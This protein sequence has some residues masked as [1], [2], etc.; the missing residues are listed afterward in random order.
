MTS[1]RARLFVSLALFIIATGLSAGALAF[2]WAFDEA[3]ELQDAILLQIGSLAAVNRLQTELPAQDGVDAEAK[4][5]IEDLRKAPD[6]GQSATT[7]PEIPPNFADGLYTLAG[8]DEAWRVLLR[9]RADGG[10]VAVAQPTAARDEIAR[11]SALRTVLP[12]GALIPCLMFLIAV[13]IHF[14]FRP[15]AQLAAKLD[16]EK[17][18]HLQPLP[19]DRMPDELRPFIGSINRLLERVAATF[20]QQRRF[21]ALAA[22]ELRTPLTALSVQADNLDHAMLAQDRQDRLA[23]LRAGIRRTAHLLEQI[24]D[25]AKYDEGA[26]PDVPA[27]RL[28]RVVKSVVADF[29]PLAGARS[30]DLGFAR[31]AETSVQIGATSLS[32]LIRNLLDNAIRHSPDGGRVDV[33]VFPEGPCA[34]L[35][36]ED[37][38]PGIPTTDI[39]RVFEPFDR[40]SRPD[41]DGTGLGLS[42]VRRIVNNGQGSII[43]ENASS[44]G[45]AGLRATVKLPLA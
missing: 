17:N 18:D 5:V 42:I 34:V 28:D 41:G 24:L 40:G 36:I 43:L 13:V 8:R 4:V 3:I 19:T 44:I 29:L 10:R 14:S 26:A 12:L 39:D 27:E 22:H 32:V 45:C 1:L 21:I 37:S 30:V 9:T 23:S 20:D 2:R 33:S 31:L 6:V 15:V 16:A 38:G 7:L 11:D 35:R 25:L